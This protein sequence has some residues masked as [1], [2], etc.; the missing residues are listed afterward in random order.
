[1]RICITAL[2]YFTYGYG[3][4]QNL[5]LAAEVGNSVLFAPCIAYKVVGCKVNVQ[6]KAFSFLKKKSSGVQGKCINICF[7]GRN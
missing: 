6:G 4:E 3:Y 7:W 5:T 1:M 2:K